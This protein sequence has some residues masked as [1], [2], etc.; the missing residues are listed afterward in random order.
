MHKRILMGVFALLLVGVAAGSALALDVGK[1][2]PAFK[3]QDQFGKTWDSAVLKDNVVVVVAANKNSGRAMDPWMGNLKDKYGTRITLIGLM[4]LHDIPGI[5]R[6]IA[7]SR[8]KKET[9]D[10]LM[11]DFGGKISKQYLVNDK[12]PVVVVIGR[13]TVVRAVQASG[14]SDA[15]YKSITSAAD[16]ALSK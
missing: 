6:G 3:L 7:K 5:G 16:A 15:A 12:N 9:K 8:I 10:P 13:G 1:A 14:Y 2:A 11:L 4:D